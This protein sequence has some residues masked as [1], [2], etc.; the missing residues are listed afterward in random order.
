MKPFLPTQ[1]P[2]AEGYTPRRQPK[3]SSPSF[4]FGAVLLFA[5]LAVPFL[6]RVLAS[7]AVS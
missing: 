7:V 1:F 4:A 5:L 3:P 6:M 2:S